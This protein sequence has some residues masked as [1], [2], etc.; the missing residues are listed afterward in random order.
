MTRPLIVRAREAHDARRRRLEADAYNLFQRRWKEA[1]DRV[2]SVSPRRYVYTYSPLTLAAER[3]GRSW[4]WSVVRRD[5]P[6]VYVSDL[7][8][9]GAYLAR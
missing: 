5:L 6:P 7:A 4:D 9:L 2:L 8:D 3:N 1:P